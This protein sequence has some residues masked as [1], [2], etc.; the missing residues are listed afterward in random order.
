MD[1]MFRNP[2]LSFQSYGNLAEAACQLD[3]ESI[4][5]KAK[6]ALETRAV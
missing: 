5:V 4:A 1:K 6:M 2:N 3:P